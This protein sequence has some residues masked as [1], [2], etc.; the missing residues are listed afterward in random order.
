MN[1][2][3]RRKKKMEE[4]EEEEQ[5]CGQKMKEKSRKRVDE[6]KER[7]QNR[8]RDEKINVV[9]YPK[10]VGNLQQRH[11]NNTKGIRLYQI[12]EALLRC[13]PYSCKNVFS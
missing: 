2:R 7:Q 10:N 5:K 3:T 6:E 1:K 13:S 4:K 9:S 8:A 12:T 11:H